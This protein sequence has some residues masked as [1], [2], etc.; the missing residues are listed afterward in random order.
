LIESWILRKR[1]EARILA[2]ELVVV[3]YGSPDS[4]GSDAPVD[5]A[6]FADLGFEIETYGSQE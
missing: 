2:G 1:V 6:D 5:L 3:L 4:A